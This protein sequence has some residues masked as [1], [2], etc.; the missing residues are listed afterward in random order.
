MGGGPPRSDGLPLS[1]FPA[2]RG[3]VNRQRPGTRAFRACGL[4]VQSPRSLLCDPLACAVLVSLRPDTPSTLR[5]KTQVLRHR[6]GAQAHLVSLSGRPR[7]RDP[8]GSHPGWLFLQFKT[9]LL[10]R[11]DT[12]ATENKEHSTQRCVYGNSFPV[13]S[14]TAEAES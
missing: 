14:L 9:T 11:T 8:L 6:W 2:P 12:E 7:S 13:W 1:A 10:V 3:H 4:S 5:S